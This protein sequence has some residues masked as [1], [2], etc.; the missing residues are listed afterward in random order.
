MATR[1]PTLDAFAVG[2]QRSTRRW[3]LSCLHRSG[4]HNQ[5][6][7][8]WLTAILDPIAA[9]GDARRART[10]ATALEATLEALCDDLGIANARTAQALAQVQAATAAQRQAVGAL[11]KLQDEVR[12]ARITQPA[13]RHQVPASV[14]QIHQRHGLTAT[15]PDHVLDA[16]EAAQLDAWTIQLPAN[17]PDRLKAKLQAVRADFAAIRRYRQL[18]RTVRHP[19][20]ARRKEQVSA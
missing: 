7:I 20:T 3:I 18:V 14:A 4:M 5:R 15:C 9:E 17:D 6:P 8:S 12:L 2:S 16:V 13:P 11:A 19:A 10:R 1:A